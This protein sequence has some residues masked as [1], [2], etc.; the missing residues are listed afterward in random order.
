MTPATNANRAGR[1][2]GSGERPPDGPARPWD[3]LAPAARTAP[4]VFASPHSGHDYPDPF[5]AASR[6][7]P[8]T[9]R[10]SEDA[11]IDEVFT[12]APAHGAP[13]LR[14]RFPRAYVDPNREAFELDPAM[15]V[16]PLPP[17]VN[18]TSPGVAAGLGTIA[19]VV[20]RGAEIYRS[21]LR[22]DEVR[23]RIEACY[24]PYHRTLRGLV[25][26]TRRRF[27]G[28]LLIDCHSMPS[29]GA[30]M[31]S[32]M[33]LGDRHA[34]ACAPGITGLAEKTLR[35][36]GFKVRRNTPFA[37]GFTARHYGAPAEGVHVLQIEINRALYMDEAAVARGSGLDFL[38]ERIGQLIAALARIDPGMLAAA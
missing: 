7:D 32:D 17:Y 29:A 34:T 33:V 11:F 30:A 18:T 4:L 23:R 10:R 13:L 8:L 36:L 26:E 25:E 31:G 12:A 21:R 9:L 16:D 35:S 38:A 3:I 37:G 28:C 14:A 27:G 24:V 5:V 19:R 2:A 6:L 15:F 1:P 22:F 20:F